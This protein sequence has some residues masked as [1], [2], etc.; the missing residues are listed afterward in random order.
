MAEPRARASQ[1]QLATGIHPADVAHQGSSAITPSSTATGSASPG[2][3]SPTTSP[4]LRS[5]SP[6][7]GMA[8]WLRTLP[9]GRPVSSSSRT[10]RRRSRCCRTRGRPR[11]NTRRCSTTFVAQGNLVAPTTSSSLR[12]HGRPGA[13][14]F[15]LT[16]R[17]ASAT[18]PASACPLGSNRR[19]AHGSLRAHLD[20]HPPHERDPDGAVQVALVSLPAA[21][22]LG[23]GLACSTHAGSEQPRRRTLHRP[24]HCG[25]YYEGG[26]PYPT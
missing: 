2:S 17:H 22:S 1:I 12:T 14:S 25:E 3:P 5:R 18:C 4:S 8:P 7:C 24:K 26:N 21:G 15:L 10:S 11:R 23:A 9:D 16:A 19:R 13:R 20:L 6:N